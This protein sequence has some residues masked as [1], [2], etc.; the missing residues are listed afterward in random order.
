MDQIDALRLLI[1][2]AEKGSFSA[3]ARNRAIA[4]STVTLAINQLEQVFGARLMARSTR[5]LTFTHEGEGLLADARRIV[6]EW[7]G[8][9]L[10]LRHG[11]ELS[12]PIKVT[13]TNDFGRSQLR[14]L[15]DAFQR[16]YPKVHISLMLNDSMV[17]LIDEHVDLALRYGPLQDSGLQARLLLRGNRMVCA[18]P[19]Y[20]D[21][22]G[23][24]AH[25]GELAGHNCLVLA[26]SGAPLT[27]WNFRD[28]GKPFSVRVHGDRQASDGAVPREWAL[29]G[30]GV[31][32]KNRQDIQKELDSG[33]LE[34]V[35]DDFAAGPI[36][37][38]AVYPGSPPSRR[39]AALVDFLADSLRPDAAATG[40]DGADRSGT[41][42]R[43]Q[44]RG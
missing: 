4:T 36:D 27:V 2:V 32:L 30:V 13:A 7:D 21:R 31:I 18:A 41:D 23:R 26:R 10:R 33:A 20:W 19:A 43:A 15:L 12:G 42:P 35:L 38:Y 24:P 11:N 28:G 25:P 14:P 29:E 1:E 17:N 16:R 22:H 5:R 37:L 40:D 3:V 8:A 39:V 6:A 9:V 34:S 44:L